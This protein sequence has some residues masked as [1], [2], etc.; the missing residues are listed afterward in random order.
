MAKRA[1]TH[2]LNATRFYNQKLSITTL[3]MK[4]TA[5]I[6][7]KASFNVF[8]EMS[9][10]SSKIIDPI[11]KFPVLSTSRTCLTSNSSNILYKDCLSARLTSILKFN[12]KL[13]KSSMPLQIERTK[14]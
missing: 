13:A 11:I 8:R 1:K 4:Q 7:V 9:S 6:I 5:S 10:K 2:L 3:N 12:L 14:I